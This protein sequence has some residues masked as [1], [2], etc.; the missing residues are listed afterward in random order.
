MSVNTETSTPAGKQ[1]SDGNSTGLIIGQSASDKLGFYGLAIPIVQPSGTV[2]AAAT[3]L[4]V[5]TTTAQWFFSTSTQANALVSLANDI[6]A[7]LVALGL[8]A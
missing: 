6:R 7:K 1:I 8:I 3:T 5:S 4:A 2:A